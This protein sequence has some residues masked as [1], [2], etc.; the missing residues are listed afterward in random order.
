MTS[1][2]G[3]RVWQQLNRGWNGAV[4]QRQSAKKLGQS[5]GI[6]LETARWIP[7][8]N[9]KFGIESTSEVKAATLRWRQNAKAVGLQSVEAFGGEWTARFLKIP[10]QGPLRAAAPRWR[11]RLHSHT[12][13]AADMDRWMG[14][15]ARPGWL[16]RLSLQC[17][18][19][20]RTARRRWRTIAA[21]RRRRRLE[22]R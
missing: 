10:F 2:S 8:A 4:R 9:C 11:F 20:H 22:H 6:R 16:Q 1:E 17:S 7:R 21:S 5:R 12:L 19:A 13:S 15:R 18:V 14:P 3:C